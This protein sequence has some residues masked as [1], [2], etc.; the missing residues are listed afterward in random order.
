[1]NKDTNLRRKSNTKSRPIM[2]SLEEFLAMGG[3]TGS[4]RKSNS[5]KSP[6]FI[7]TVV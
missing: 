7:A 4:Y 1:M 2:T 6:G 5:G 3:R